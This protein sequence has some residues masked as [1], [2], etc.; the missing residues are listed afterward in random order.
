MVWELQPQ[1]DSRMYLQLHVHLAVVANVHPDTLFQ[2]AAVV[3][4]FV[5]VAE[6]V[7]TA[8]AGE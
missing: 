5:G 4:V 2:Y 8:G 1:A 7:Y 6:E 3:K